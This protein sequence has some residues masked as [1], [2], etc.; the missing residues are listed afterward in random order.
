MGNKHM[1]I[2]QRKK[3]VS[4]VELNLQFSE[5]ILNRGSAQCKSMRS[6][7]SLTIEFQKERINYTWIQVHPH[8]CKMS[9]NGYSTH[10]AHQRDICSWVAY[11]LRLIDD[12]ITPSVI[13]PYFVVASDVLEG[14]HKGIG[15]STKGGWISRFQ[16][17]FVNN[18]EQS[19]SSRGFQPLGG[20]VQQ[21]WGNFALPHSVVQ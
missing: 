11:F 13:R 4:Y 12:H 6:F 8:N 7:Q 15:R 20:L 10:L 17:G 18:L 16:I 2:F 5:I 9:D 21:Q 3:T 1:V 19:V 14:C